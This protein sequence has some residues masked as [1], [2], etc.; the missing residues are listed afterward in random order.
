MSLLIML[1]ILIVI[2]VVCF[3]DDFTKEHI[4]KASPFIIV[5]SLVLFILGAF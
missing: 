3:K 4:D 5:V 1:A 2:Y